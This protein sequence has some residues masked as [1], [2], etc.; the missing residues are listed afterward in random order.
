MSISSLLRHT[1]ATPAQTPPFSRC[2]CTRENTFSAYG[3]RSHA[4][5]RRY[6]SPQ[7]QLNTRRDALLFTMDVARTQSVPRRHALE[8]VPTGNS[9][10][11]GACAGNPPPP[12]HCPRSLSLPHSISLSLSFVAT[13][14]CACYTAAAAAA[15]D[16][17]ERA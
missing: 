17:A 11:K 16:I 12:S 13:L 3:T 9:H 6:N 8:F 14:L 5:Q 1:P 2:S 10:R 15:D 4:P 7:P